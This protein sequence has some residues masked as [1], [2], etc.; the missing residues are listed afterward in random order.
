[1]IKTQTI[2]SLIVVAIVAAAGICLLYG[3]NGATALPA[4]TAAPASPE[5]GGQTR[6]PEIYAPVICDNGKVYVNQCFADKAHAKNCVP[7]GAAA[8]SDECSSS[9]AARPPINCPDIVKPVICDNGVVYP[10]LCYAQRAGAKN[11]VPY[12]AQTN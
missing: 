10:N 7:Y 11:C 12:E 8:I 1:M 6:C 5:T 4:A 3:S 9:D 2:A